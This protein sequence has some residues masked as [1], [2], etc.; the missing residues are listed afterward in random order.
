M[1]PWGVASLES[2]VLIS[3]IYVE[4]HQTLLYTKY[5]SCGPQGFG[6]EDFFYVFSLI[7]LWEIMTPGAW[8]V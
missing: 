4:H 7:G 5:I 1:T 8:P 3:R 2:R 6:E